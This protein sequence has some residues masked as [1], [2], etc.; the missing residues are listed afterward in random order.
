[1]FAPRMEGKPF[2]AAVEFPN[3]FAELSNPREQ[4]ELGVQHLLRRLTTPMFE[5]GEIKQ[6]RYFDHIQTELN[7]YLHETLHAP[8]DVSVTVMAAGGNVRTALAVLYEQMYQ[9]YVTPPHVPPAQTLGRLLSE[10]HD[11]GGYRDRGAASDWDLVLDGAGEYT[12]ALIAHAKQISNAV[13]EEFL[14]RKVTLSDKGAVFAIPDV[15]G[16]QEQLGTAVSQGGAALD[17][18]CFDVRRGRFVEPASQRAH[19]LDLLDGV[20]AGKM[21]YFAPT[22]PDLVS[23]PGKQT[24]RGLR[25]LLELPFL[26]YGDEGAL[27]AD[28][29]TLL[30]S[31][32][33]AE[34]E[35]EQMQP[36]FRQ[37]RKLVN[38]ERGGAGNNRAYRGAPGSIDEKLG[39]VS[40]ALARV[41][42]GHP[43]EESM[44]SRGMLIPEFLPRIPSGESSLQR[45]SALQALDTNPALNP[46]SLLMDEAHLRSSLTDSGRLYFRAPYEQML[47]LLRSGPSHPPRATRAQGGL[48]GA[49][50]FAKRRDGLLGL[51][52]Q[53]DALL[54]LQLRRDRPQCFLDWNDVASTPAMRR[55]LSEAEGDLGAVFERLGLEYVV[56]GIIYERKVYLQNADA[57]VLGNSTDEII[58]SFGSL[59]ETLGTGPS[60]EVPIARGTDGYADFAALERK[61]ALRA[62]MLRDYQILSEFAALGPEGETELKF[63][64]PS[65]FLLALNGGNVALYARAYACAS[66]EERVLRETPR[67]VALQFIERSAKSWFGLISG[68]P[69]GELGRRETLHDPAF[70]SEGIGIDVTAEAMDTLQPEEVFARED[71]AFRH[72]YAGV[73]DPSMVEL[74]RLSALS[75]LTAEDQ[76][77]LA[78]GRGQGD[79]YTDGVLLPTAV[80]RL[81]DDRGFRARTV[82]LGR[83]RNDALGSF[84]RE[85]MSLYRT[86]RSYLEVLEGARPFARRLRAE[87]AMSPPEPP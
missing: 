31:L 3:L 29:E 75:G 20:V 61:F 48:R 58:R 54:E 85:L 45:L 16:Y 14:E 43:V 15:K 22:R 72:W 86:G 80:R 24:V 38:N 23:N 41:Q 79:E 6:V 1:M 68:G 55:L 28:L 82:Q 57:L 8:E 26:R 69:R 32:R 63:I 84:A 77:G 47:G 52:G 40:A 76:L 9:A 12:N 2:D 50:M 42:A 53:R 18:L 51:D 59:L 71:A 87:L 46:Q 37:F 33:T 34:P 19:P 67:D 7:R 10:H 81:F 27:R 70:F 5:H 39:E 83:Q 30:K 17:W 13:G 73:A 60:A 4:L 25:A 56:D 65:V 36:I 44:N 64:Q 66:P 78:L 11:L 49:E 35:S 74:A 62:Q 21:E